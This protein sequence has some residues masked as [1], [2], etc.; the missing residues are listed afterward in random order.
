[1]PYKSPSRL[2]RGVLRRCRPG[3]FGYLA[4]CR[5]IRVLKNF[6]ASSLFCVGKPE[7]KLTG[8][9]IDHGDEIFGGT[10]SPG[11]GFGRLDQTVDAFQDPVG[12][13]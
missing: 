1:M 4:G 11:L 8:D 5:L 2:I 3:G 6:L 13:A 12:D 9:E 7:I 10:V